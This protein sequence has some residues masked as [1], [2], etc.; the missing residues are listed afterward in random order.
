MG[1]ANDKGFI[2]LGD[3]VK[4]AIMV[5]GGYYLKRANALRGQKTPQERAD[6][7]DEYC[8]SLMKGFLSGI[9][10]DWR[11]RRDSNPRY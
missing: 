9:L 8:K 1:C 6:E 10:I 11:R 2:V 5:D 7:L 3:K 4:T